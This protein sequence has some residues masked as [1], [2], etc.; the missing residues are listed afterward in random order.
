M[1]K[2]SG[3][4]ES[5]TGP[6]KGGVGVGG[7]GGDN[8]DHD[9]E[10]SPQG[11]R[12]AHQR[13]HQLAR[14]RLWLSLME[15]MLVVVLLASRSKGCQKFVKKSSK[16]SENRQRAQKASRSKKFAKDIGLEKRLPKHQSSVNE[17]L[18]LLLKL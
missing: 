5:T 8:R 2:T 9:C 4:T 3:S 13:T 12:Q 10:H 11:S 6:G 17:E 15:L 14:P 1:L 7:N 16:R 18:K